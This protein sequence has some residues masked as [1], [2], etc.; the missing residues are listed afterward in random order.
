MQLIHFSQHFPV[1]HVK[2]G[3]KTMFV[4]KLCNN[5][6]VQY[7]SQ[8][9][10]ESLLEWNAESIL[11]GKLTVADIVSFHNSLL[12]CLGKKKHTLRVSSKYREGNKYQPVVWS[13]KP[14]C[15]PIIRFLPPISVYNTQSFEFLQHR[16]SID[17]IIF[18]EIEQL[19]Y[20][21]G[22]SLEDFLVWFWS[23]KPIQGQI[24][25]FDETL[26]YLNS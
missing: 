9:Y 12:P 17:K 2:A 16:V 7:L 10:L 23:K 8:E 25:H 15:S 18:K 24:I 14:Y 6:D 13:R 19:A 3:Q 20:N 11:L 4:E 26:K 1:S 21:D 5:F 22:L